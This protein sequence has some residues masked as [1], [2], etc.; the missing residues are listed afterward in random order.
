M[1][2]AKYW[3]LEP[4]HLATSS[5]GNVAGDFQN[6]NQADLEIKQNPGIQY[7][8]NDTKIF[9]FAFGFVFPYKMK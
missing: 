1:S 3:L 7:Q 9:V 2:F 6:K 4:L 8:D 5:Y